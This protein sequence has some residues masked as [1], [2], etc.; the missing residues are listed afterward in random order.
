VWRT[1]LSGSVKIVVRFDAADRYAVVPND[2]YRAE[3]EDTKKL[4]LD[5]F[6]APKN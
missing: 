4:F 5:Q 3:W 1:A 2:R 6:G